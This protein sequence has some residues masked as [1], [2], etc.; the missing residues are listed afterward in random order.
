M[1]LDPRF[2]WHQSPWSFPCS[3]SYRISWSHVIRA[4]FQSLWN[5]N[6]FTTGRP[7]PQ[8]HA[9]Y[10][11]RLIGAKPQRV[12]WLHHPTAPGSKL[13]GNDALVF[14]GF[15]NHFTPATSWLWAASVNK[16]PIPTGRQPSQLWEQ[17]SSPAVLP[18]DSDMPWPMQTLL[19]SSPSGPKGRP[20]LAGGG[21]EPPSPSLH[22]CHQLNNLMDTKCWQQ[23][24]ID[25]QPML[26]AI[27]LS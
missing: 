27:S 5:P 23:F 14:W 11:I 16:S 19:S 15:G 12:R 1:D 17:P 2:C 26:A 25:S 9:I 21:S 8:H 10:V 22:L 20:Q 13:Q 24:I 4:W 6:S 18:G 3:S 7:T